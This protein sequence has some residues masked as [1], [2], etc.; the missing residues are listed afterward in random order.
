MSITGTRKR[1]TSFLSIKESSIP[2]IS[3]G[4][5][6]R[7]LLCRKPR[8]TAKG[9]GL[10]SAPTGAGKSRGAH[11]CGK[12]DNEAIESITRYSMT[13]DPEDLILPAECCKEKWVNYKNI[14][15]A[16]PMDFRI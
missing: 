9:A 16:T 10:M 4:G 1:E 3:T 2:A 13:G 6:Q 14:S 15:A 7:G 11:N 12:C 8:N 5:M